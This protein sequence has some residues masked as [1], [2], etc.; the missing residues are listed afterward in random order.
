MVLLTGQ[1]AAVAKDEHH[2]F[3]K[4]PAEI[5]RV[6]AGEGV[7]GDAHRGITVRHRSRIAVDPTQPNLRQVHL[8]QAE[9]FDE[10]RDRGVVVA[11]G[12]LG[13][14]ITTRGMGLLDLPQGTLLA[15][16]AHAVLAVTGLRNPCGQIERYQPGLLA[17]VLRTD[18]R[19]TTI[20]KAGVM[21]IV[22]ASGSIC[23]GDAIAVTLPPLP[24]RR[25]ERV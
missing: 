22:K 13:E 7:E 8:I 16:G 19:G 1:V 24:H 12:D 18:Q 14:N 23:P 9:S 3:S 4:P 11:P 10:L 20:R 25:L 6:I 17:A 2:R 21:A 5:L 15:I